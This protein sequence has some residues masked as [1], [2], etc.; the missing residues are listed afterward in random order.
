MASEL[1]EK[2]ESSSSESQN[3]NNIIDTPPHTPTATIFVTSKSTVSSI[4]IYI[5]IFFF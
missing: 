2:N 1:E 4:G 3:K 5:Y